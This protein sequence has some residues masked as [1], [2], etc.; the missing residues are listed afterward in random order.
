MRLRGARSNLARRRQAFTG[1]YARWLAK[2]L[3]HLGKARAGLA[4]FDAAEASLLE[5]RT[6]SVAARGES[7][8]DTR[9]C[10]Q[11]LVELYTKRHAAEPGK[12]YDLDEK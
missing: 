8:K 6:V 3:K 12:L 10:T 1:A 4:Q 7:H 5:A 11:A 9:E 2:L